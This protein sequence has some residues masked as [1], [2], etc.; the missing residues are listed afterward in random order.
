MINKIT[1]FLFG[2]QYQSNLDDI[3]K[4][5]LRILFGLSLALNHG[6][7]TLKGVLNGASE[8][9]DPLGLGTELSML[10]AGSAEFVFTLLVALGLFTRVSLIPVLI[11]F[12]VA[13]FIFH[14]GDPFG[15]KE[16]AYIYLSAMSTIMLLGPGKYSLDYFLFRHLK[17]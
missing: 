11:N 13:F 12:I 8:F 9:P 14:S 15:R 5:A 3:G 2:G 4:L 6:L 1:T 7:P 10:F 17:N 16:L